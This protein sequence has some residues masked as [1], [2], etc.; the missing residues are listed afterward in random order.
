MSLSLISSSIDV[1]IT[2]S[3]FA[4]F[5]LNK[6]PNR[7][8][9]I[10]SHISKLWFC[11]YCFFEKL[12]SYVLYKLSTHASPHHFLNI[13]VR[14][15]K[16]HLSALATA[17]KFLCEKHKSKLIRCDLWMMFCEILG[18]WHR[19]YWFILSLAI[20]PKVYFVNQEPRESM[21]LIRLKE[22]RSQAFPK[23]HWFIY[24]YT[25]SINWYF[26][27]FATLVVY[28]N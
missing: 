1:Y 7:W 16:L 26:S 17:D 28:G 6:P 9:H 18:K 14:L 2:I 4:L 23:T 8:K 12:S 22:H 3:N 19:H 25:C 5:G 21:M 15:L 11:S 24:A 27:S 10:N 20:W 13:S